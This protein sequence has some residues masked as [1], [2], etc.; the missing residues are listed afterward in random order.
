M[1]WIEIL[2]SLFAVSTKS[3]TCK[4]AGKGTYNV[5]FDST[6]CPGGHVSWR[7][8]GDTHA[9]WDQGGSGQGYYG[10][11]NGRFYNTAVPTLQPCFNSFRAAKNP[12]LSCDVPLAE[13]VDYNSEEYNS[14]NREFGDCNYGIGDAWFGDPT[15]FGRSIA[16]AANKCQSIATSLASDFK[17]FM[18]KCTYSETFSSATLSIYKTGDCTGTVIS[19]ETLADGEYYCCDNCLTE[20]NIYQMKLSEFNGEVECGG[21]ESVSYNY[22]IYAD[23]SEDCYVT[24]APIT[25]RQF[26]FE[27]TSISQEIF[28]SNLNCTGSASETLTFNANKCEYLSSLDLTYY[29][30]IPAVDTDKAGYHQ[31]P[32]ISFIFCLLILRQFL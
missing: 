4:S 13:D 3:W 22:H 2:F 16:F 20:C 26:T 12:N 29:L 1:I 23:I 21:V 19:V 25:S 6:N 28:N 8:N 17:S 27:D 5:C 24:D 31:S 30:E 7:P 15:G 18:V 10:C 14:I 32:N 11:V 9:S